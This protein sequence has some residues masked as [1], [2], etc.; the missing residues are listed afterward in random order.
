MPKWVRLLDNCDITVVDAIG[1]MIACNNGHKI[2]LQLH[3]FQYFNFRG[4][5]H[6]LAVSER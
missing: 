2:F 5:L 1:L 4:L 3:I 6:I